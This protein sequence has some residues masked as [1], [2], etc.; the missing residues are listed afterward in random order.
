MIIT[1]LLLRWYHHRHHHHHPRPYSQFHILSIH[2][3]SFS[4]I[5]RFRV[6]DLV[7]F[8]LHAFLRLFAILL[9]E[10]LLSAV[11]LSK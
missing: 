10:Q 4:V 8:I 6:Q 5:V 1:L 7:L 3:I 9:A 2:I 11:T